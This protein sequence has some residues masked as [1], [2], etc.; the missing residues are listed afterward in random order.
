MSATRK[1]LLI[2]TA[3]G[4]THAAAFLIGSLIVTREPARAETP[5]PVS[6]QSPTAR[7]T[8]R[9]RDTPKRVDS[10]DFPGDWQQLHREPMAREDFEKSRRAFLKEWMKRDLGAVLDVFYG[11]A[12]KGTRP[13]LD[14]EVSNALYQQIAA[15]APEVLQWIQQGRFG[16]ARQEMFSTWFSAIQETPNRSLIISEFNRMTPYERTWSVQSLVDRLDPH[17]MAALRDQIV[18]GPKHDLYDPTTHNSY[19]RRMIALAWENPESVFAQENDPALLRALGAAWAQK[20][21]GSDPDPAKLDKFTELPE[22]ARP[23]ALNAILNAADERM[24][25][26]VLPV[27]RELERLQCWK[28]LAGEEAA[29]AMLVIAERKGDAAKLTAEWVSQLANAEARQNLTKSVALGYQRTDQA[30]CLRWMETLPAGPER[31]ATLDALIRN[32]YGNKDFQKGA[33]RLVQNPTLSA[34]LA[35]E[36]PDLR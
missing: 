32:S 7:E 27:F 3:L 30:G 4:V 18:T 2:L 26:G 15:Q 31:D 6:R 19:A 16:S 25:A 21:F 1:P 8:K 10:D 23:G 13:R 11:P 22:A 17:E 24:V 35:A 28:D 20:R 36:I 29:H 33:F 34:K 14:G 12:A 5:A 9:E